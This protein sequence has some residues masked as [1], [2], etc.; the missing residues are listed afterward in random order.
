VRSLQTNDLL[1]LDE[2]ILELHTRHEAVLG[3]ERDFI[4]DLL[5]QNKPEPPSIV[6]LTF[7][8]VDDEILPEIVLLVFT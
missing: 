5:G 1:N 6:I 3:V 7:G 4:E 8:N 2:S